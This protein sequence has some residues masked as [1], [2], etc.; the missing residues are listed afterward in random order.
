MSAD[1]TDA[2]P[3][4]NEA[5]TTGKDQGES[6]TAVSSSPLGKLSHPQSHEAVQTRWQSGKT[7]EKQ[8]PHESESHSIP[9]LER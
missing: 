3:P 4:L 6:R 2:S 7:H 1:E 9:T 5:E 8:P